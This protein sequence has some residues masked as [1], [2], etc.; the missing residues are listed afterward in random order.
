[1]Y[2]GVTQ[3]EGSGGPGLMQ[4]LRDRKSLTTGASCSNIDSKSTDDLLAR[5]API[6]PKVRINFCTYLLL[7]NYMY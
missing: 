4:F 3:T 7:N 5:L 6:I 1:M 2:V